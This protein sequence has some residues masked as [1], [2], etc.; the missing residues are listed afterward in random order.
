MPE[1]LNPLVRAKSWRASIF[2]VLLAACSSPLPEE[3]SAAASLYRER[4][5]GCHRVYSPRSL[6]YPL[7]EVIVGRMQ[8]KI[9][10]SGGTPLA[11]E[12]RETILAYLRKHASS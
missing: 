7:W 8:A 10:Q 9:A 2:A 11:R 3:G 6:K 12:E 5:G 4:C 1:R